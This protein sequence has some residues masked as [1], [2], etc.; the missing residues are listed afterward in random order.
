ML[1]TVIGAYYCATTAPE[2]FFAIPFSL[3]LDLWARNL[4]HASEDVNN[5][6]YQVACSFLKTVGKDGIERPPIDLGRYSQDGSAHLGSP[7]QILRYFLACG[8]QVRSPHVMGRSAMVRS[9]L[10]RGIRA[11][12]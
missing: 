12:L 9:Q 5:L 11:S 2:N 4:Q 10:R 3:S 7:V 8:S 6:E 1:D